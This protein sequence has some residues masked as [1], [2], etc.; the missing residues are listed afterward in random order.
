MSDSFKERNQIVFG[1]TH[2]D[3][4]PELDFAC[5]N[6]TVPRIVK[7]VN[8]MEQDKDKDA[9][10]S[11]TGELIGRVWHDVFQEE[12]WDYVRKNHIKN[13]DFKKAESYCLD[14]TKVLFFDYL[15]GF[16]SVANSYEHGKESS[17]PEGD[18]GE[19]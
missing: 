6:V 1:N 13:F 3:S 8:K 12:L 15:D 10:K 2:K 19:R 9:D 14:R 17:V 5:A 7:L 16:S 11:F 18:S 4:M